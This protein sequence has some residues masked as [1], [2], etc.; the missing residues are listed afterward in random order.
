MAEKETAFKDDDEKL[1]PIEEKYHV[2]LERV[3]LGQE[4]PI[5][6]FVKTKIEG[7]TYNPRLGYGFYEFTK[8]ELISYD[9]QVIVMDQVFELGSTFE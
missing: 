8:P 2:Q 6:D 5:L 1:S 3:P 9:K 4:Y 7:V